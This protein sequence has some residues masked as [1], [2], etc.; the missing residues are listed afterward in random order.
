MILGSNQRGNA[1][2]VAEDQERKLISLETFFEHDTGA[3]V[4]DH[5]SAEHLGGDADRLVFGGGDHYAFACGQAVGFDGDWQMKVAESGADLVEGIAD[6]EV[7]GRNAMALQKFLGETLAGL[8][9]GG[10][11][12]RAE[13]AP[14]AAVELVD[15]A[16]G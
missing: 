1:F 16:E 6:G 7:S 9:L 5:A 13:D 12:R 8:K 3:G 2:A 4:A 14:S 10:R 11:L 15:Y